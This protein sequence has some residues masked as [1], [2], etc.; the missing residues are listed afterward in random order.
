MGVLN[1]EEPGRRKLRRRSRRASQQF[2]IVADQDPA[3]VR[4]FLRRVRR[5]ARVAGIRLADDHAPEANGADRRPAPAAEA[6]RY[7]QDSLPAQRQAVQD[8][9]KAIAVGSARKTTRA[10]AQ[11]GGAEAKCA[12]TI[13]DAGKRPVHLS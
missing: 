8:I 10:R 5:A 1:K 13:D 9:L 7:T 12:I 3:A 2:R 6:F 11:A 4:I